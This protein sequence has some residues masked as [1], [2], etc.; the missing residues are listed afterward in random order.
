[1]VH[2]AAQAADIRLYCKRDDLYTPAPGTALQG[3]KVRKL[4]GFIQAALTQEQ[5]PLLMSFGGAF[6]N[7]LSALATAGKL[8]GI[9]VVIYVRGEEAANA[10]LSRAE[11][12]GARLIRLSRAEYRLKYNNEWLSARR[13]ELATEYGLPVSAVWPIA[14]GG[15]CP[16]SARSVGHLYEEVMNQ[17][18]EA[19]DYLCLS[20]GTGG[21]AASIIQAAAQT[22][23][24]EVF[25]ALK[26][27]WM[28]KEIQ[29]LLPEVSAKNW[30]C[31]N[32]YHFG[33]YG[34]FPK[35]WII[36][37]DGLA[38]IADIGEPGLPL[39]E[40]IYTAKLFYGVLDRVRQGVY[41]PGSR[42]VVV[43]TGG[44]Y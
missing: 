12:D 11:S 4:S 42:V 35:E 17:L 5:S 29:G 14:E 31:I 15:T 44:I 19:P 25:P 34:K 8:Y 33:G 30:A 16:G 1:M 9:P 20:A 13:K 37:S 24:V 28:D 39:L 10:I 22:T 21:S 27:N 32:E 40:P 23:T 2:P 38:K 26:G 6:S 36:A 41:P 18:G 7:H 3:N 43:H